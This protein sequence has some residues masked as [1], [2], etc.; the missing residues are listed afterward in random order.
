M[1]SI[2]CKRLTYQACSQKF[3]LTISLL[4]LMLDHMMVDHMSLVDHMSFVDRM[5]LV[6]HMML[7]HMI[8]DHV[9]LDHMSFIL[10]C[11]AD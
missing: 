11:M 6:D 5:S 9:M 7:N 1:T 4:E 2:A 3:I 10:N 8:V